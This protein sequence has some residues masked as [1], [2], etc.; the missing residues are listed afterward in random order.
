M[1]KTKII[2][3]AMVVILA[4]AFVAATM[5]QTSTSTATG[6]VKPSTTATQPV[7]KPATPAS[8]PT[9]VKPAAPAQITETKVV[10][11]V[12][13]KQTETKTG[14]KSTTPKMAKAK[15]GTKK[16]AA[17]AE[18]GMGKD[19]ATTLIGLPE[20]KMFTTD[21]EK[22]GLFAMLKN[23]GPFT[24]FVPTDSA[25]AKL[26]IGA[27]DSLEADQPRLIDVLKYHIIRGKQDEASLLKT[28]SVAT[29]DKRDVMVMN[30]DGKLM[31]GDAWITKADIQCSNGVIHFIDSVLEPPA[32]GESMPMEKT[33]GTMPAGK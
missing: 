17:K 21:L 13:A 14:M 27:K 20:A 11:P 29:T 33:G 1:R 9:T 22:S 18:K 3:I 16:A 6:T 26:S 19:I 8:T 23:S 2:M 32:K 30:H 31:V 24:V 10:Q 12:A 4:F 25:F 7:A 15:M 28:S 5:A